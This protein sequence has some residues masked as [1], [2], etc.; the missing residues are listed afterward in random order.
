MMVVVMVMMM[1][2]WKGKVV[3]V[4]QHH[5]MT[6]C[7]EVKVMSYT[8]DI[9][10]AA[11][12]FVLYGLRNDL[13]GWVYHLLWLLHVRPA[14]QPTITIVALCQTRLDALPDTFLT[15]MLDCDNGRLHAR[16]RRITR[17]SNHMANA[18]PLPLSK[19]AP[20]DRGGF[21][22]QI[23]PACCIRVAP[24]FSCLAS[25]CVSCVQLDRC[26]LGRHSHRVMYHY[27]EL[28][29]IVLIIMLETGS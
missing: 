28:V 25:V 21:S 7:K 14:D 12:H 27:E 5:E 29:T 1:I 20:W 26:L 13:D 4:L 15:L 10:P 23:E 3:C 16:V 19:D 22:W 11:R 9:Q 6:T 17:W 24:L 2:K 8:T 18:L